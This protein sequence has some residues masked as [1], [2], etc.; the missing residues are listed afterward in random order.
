MYV[1]HEY[2]RRFF[3]ERRPRGDLPNDGR[4]SLTADLIALRHTHLQKLYLAFVEG[5]QLFPLPHP[6]R[7]FTNISL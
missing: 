3:A 1:H 4:R 6:R 7:N 5:I 2:L